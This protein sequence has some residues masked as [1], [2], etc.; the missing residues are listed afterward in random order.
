MYIWVVLATFMALL[1]A[2]NLSIRGDERRMAIEPLAEAEVARFAIHHRMGQQYIREHT[3]KTDE[4]PAGVEGDF[5]TYDKGILNYNTD[6]ADY[7][8]FGFQVKPYSA[9][10]DEGYKTEIYCSLEDDWGTEAPSCSAE[11]VARFLVTYG[12]IPKRWLNR[13][14]DT[15]NNDFLNALQNTF[16]IDNTIG[17]ATEATGSKYKMQLQGREDNVLYL[18]NLVVD[19]GGF[20]QLCGCS[21]CRRCL[22]YFSTYITTKQELP[23]GSSSGGS[24]SGGSSSGGSSSSSGGS[25]SSSGGSSSSSGG[26]TSSGGKP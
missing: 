25:S 14:S 12:P 16:E 23:A 13:N 2:F 20:S 22:V 3:P 4:N 17:Y 7:K 24:S 11:G 19:T 6:L 8:P 21:G 26:S 15:P 10:E 9:S 18:P 1:Y 5:I